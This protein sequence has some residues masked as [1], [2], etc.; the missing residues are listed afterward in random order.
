MLQAFIFVVVLVN[1]HRLNLTAIFNAL[2]VCA[3]SRRYS[4]WAVLKSGVVALCTFYS[5]ESKLCV[6]QAIQQQ[7]HR[8]NNGH[9][10]SISVWMYLKQQREI[11]EYALRPILPQIRI[12]MWG[13]TWAERYNQMH[14]FLAP[15]NWELGK[16]AW[17]H[18]AACRKKVNNCF[19]CSSLPRSL[20]RSV[21][22][23]VQ[24]KYMR[25]Y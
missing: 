22:I 19:P 23:V 1:S 25:S 16:L 4:I 12:E 7:A 24:N 9:W 8:A 14:I 21:N 15:A 6:I 5:T 17:L 18:Q 3:R 20:G 11:V 2:A 10:I 13:K